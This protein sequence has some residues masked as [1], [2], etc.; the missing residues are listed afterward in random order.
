MTRLEAFQS[1]LVQMMRRQ[2]DLESQMRMIRAILDAKGFV[3]DAEFIEA[4]H[5]A[6]QRDQELRELLSLSED[7][8]WAELLRRF[9]GTEQ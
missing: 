5:A 3:S 9:Q 7:Q 2:L 6:Q 4:E 1:I 8:V